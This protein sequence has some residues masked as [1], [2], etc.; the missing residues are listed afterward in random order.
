MQGCSQLNAVNRNI[1]DS[2]SNPSASAIG[3]KSGTEAGS[4]GIRIPRPER[5]D[6]PLDPEITDQDVA[7]LCQIAPFKDVDPAAFSQSISLEG[8]LKNDCRIHD[9]KKGDI[10]VREGDY[11]SSAF[12][13]LFGDALVALKSLPDAVLGR[14]NSK[15]KGWAKQLAQLWNNS[16][17]AETRDYSNRQPG[18]E[19]SDH[20]GGTGERTDDS[21]THIFLHDIPR[22]IKPGESL[23]LGAGEFFGEI[24]A[25]TRSARSATIVANGTMRLLEIRWQGF[26]EMMKRHAAMSAHIEKLYRENSLRAHLREVDLLK[27]LDQET[28]SQLADDAIFESFGNFQ[29]NTDFKSTQKKDIS[30]R[31]LSEPVITGQGEYV[32]GLVL[33]RSGFARL[34][35]QHG[36]GHQTIAYLGKG[37]A[38]GLRELMHNW[39][40]GEQRPWLLS[41]RAVG[42]VDVLRIPTESVERL[43]LPNLPADKIPQPMPSKESLTGKKDQRQVKRDDSIDPGL[44]EFLVENRYMNGTQARWLSILIAARVAMIVY[45]PAHRLTIIILAS[46]GS[47]Q[48]TITGWSPTLACIASIRFA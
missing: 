22:V 19:N 14:S 1:D 41:L 13:I 34:S 16:S 35:R 24:S 38:V 28:I 7:E 46:I 44:M 32:N 40:T 36:E 30:A 26:R 23:T 2:N 48:N 20:G 11:G 29:W 47:V 25:L 15:P 27:S 8:I 39:K 42:Y 3:A 6:L 18:G 21:G 45:G 37:Q 10:I 12:L 17:H 4:I 33:I 5:W 43:I 31:V 9:L